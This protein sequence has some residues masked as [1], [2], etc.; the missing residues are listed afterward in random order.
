MFKDSDMI[1]KIVKKI[2]DFVSCKECGGYVL[3]IV[4][5]EEGRPCTERDSEYVFDRMVIDEPD[6]RQD[7]NRRDRGR[8][9]YKGHK[10][11]RDE[12]IKPEGH[13]LYEGVRE[14]ECYPEKEECP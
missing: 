11:K 7:N 5:V 10:I 12:E 9:R 4:P 8:E 3:L 1:K 13:I 2:T 14:D 6:S